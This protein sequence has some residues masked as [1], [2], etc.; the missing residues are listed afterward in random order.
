MESVV[1]PETR[2]AIR[3]WRWVRALG[4]IAVIATALLAARLVWEQTWL[5]WSHGPQM[6]GFSLAHGDYAPL[7]ASP[8]FLLLWLVVLVGV[9][10]VGLVR[11]RRISRAVWLDVGTAAAVLG[12]LLVPYR[13]WQ[14]L[15]V[16]RLAASPKAGAFMVDAAAEG[17]LRLVQALASHGVSIDISNRQGKTGLHAAALANRVQVLEFLVGR[18]AAIDALD[19]YGDS[20]LE[21]A[22]SNEAAEAARFLEA[23]GAHRIRG[24]DVQREK[25]ASEIVREDIEEMD[26][27]RG[28]GARREE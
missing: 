12:L 2:N 18:G 6:V 3:C 26:R 1:N 11:K 23:R 24:S 25:A 10:V 13:T 19:R 4:A 14:W 15:F 20:P 9:V 7:L 16:G 17:D 27:G 28:F 8:F 22:L 21:V 5:T